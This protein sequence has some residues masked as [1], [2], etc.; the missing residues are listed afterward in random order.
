MLIY[1]MFERLSPEDIELLGL[2]PRG[3]FNSPS[4][5]ALFGVGVLQGAGEALK[6]STWLPLSLNSGSV[7]LYHDIPKNCDINEHICNAHEHLAIVC[8]EYILSCTGLIKQSSR[9]ETV[10]S[11]AMRYWTN[12]L[13]HAAHSERLFKTLRR[14]A[15][16]ERDVEHVIEWLEASHI[17]TTLARLS[18]LTLYALRLQ[19]GTGTP[20]D[21]L[22]RWRDARLEYNTKCLQIPGLDRSLF[23]RYADDRNYSGLD[24]D[25]DRDRWYIA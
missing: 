23:H 13:R 17:L 11:Y 1:A 14:A 5:Q 15:I 20:K 3:L 16:H 7:K 25:A 21:I 10:R 12:H 24:W 9:E 2:V 6:L 19:R 4:M 18:I 8:V 22:L